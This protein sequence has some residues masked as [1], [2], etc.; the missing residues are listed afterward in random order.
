M[1]RPRLLPV[2][3][4]YDGQAV[5]TVRF[6]N[7]T[8]VGD[9]FN[10]VRLFSQMQVDGLILLD[11]EASKGNK[12]I[13][14]HF[15]RQLAD[16]AAM[17]L[18][19]GG[20]ISSLSQ[21]EFLLQSGA[22]QIIVCTAAFLNPSFVT[23]LSKTFGKSSVVVSF[24]IQQTSA[25]QFNLTT[26]SGR[27]VLNGTIKEWLTIMEEAGAGEI[28]LHSVDRDGTQTGY[29]EGAIST[30]I[31]HTQLPITIL[32][33]A[34]PH[35]DFRSLHAK[36]PINGYAAGSRFLFYKNSNSVLINYPNNHRA[37]FLE[38]AHERVKSS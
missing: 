1:Y 12:P 22:E 5:K 13:H 3:Q 38:N 27:V 31:G 34:S 19:I 9:A 28:L 36:F 23:E 24:D 32:G 29:D 4:L 15:I 10:A 35:T 2:I 11:I 21:A 30:F 37:L 7:P 16:M 20:G 14:Q 26:A 8:Y 33:G 18:A 17:P 25:G 6:N